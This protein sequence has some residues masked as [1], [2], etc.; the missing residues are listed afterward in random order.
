MTRDDPPTAPF[1]I[2]TGRPRTVGELA[3]ALARASGDLAPQ[4]VTT[5]DYRLGDVRHVFASPAR[6][7]AELGFEA[8]EDFDL[9]IREFARAPL[10]RAADEPFRVP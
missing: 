3:A 7:A 4:P 8:T 10:R 6:A 1:N 5:G 2:A 9:G